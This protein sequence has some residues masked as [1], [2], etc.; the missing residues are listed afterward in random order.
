MT[1]LGLDHLRMLVAL[2]ETATVTEAAQVLGITQPAL[3]YRIREAERRTGT[4]LFSRMNKRLR[5][6]PA[7][8]RLLQ[9][10]RIILSELERA[11]SDLEKIASGIRHIVRV[12]SR[13]YS[14]YHW[15][16]PFLQEF[17]RI[18]PE[19]DVEIVQDAASQPLEALLRGELDVAIASGRLKRWGVRTI[20]LFPDELVAITTPDHPLA[21]KRFV[22]AEDFA[23]ETFV[24][25]SITSEPGHEDDL[26][27]RPANIFPKRNIKAGLT[28]A[29]IELVRA[30]FGV[31]ILSRWVVEPHVQSGSLTAVPITKSGLYMD[32]Q[33]VIRASEKDDSPA[34]K[35]SAELSQWCE[36]AGRS[37][38][39]G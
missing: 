27:F 18:A 11:Q 33:A 17:Q 19:I 12:G 8:E 2:A 36:R 4:T 5:M 28:E 7:A 29:I 3:T 35:L 30:G 26:L 25:Y 32:W 14:G 10:A 22:V 21:K 20:P 37:P 13:A 1:L 39:G 38:F 24:C 23:D 34:L 6:T 31:S 9:S 16:P 15:L